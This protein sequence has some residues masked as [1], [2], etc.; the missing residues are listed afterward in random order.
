[1]IFFINSFKQ[2]RTIPGDQNKNSK[3]SRT[4]ARNIQSKQ[5]QQPQPQPQLQQQPQLQEQQPQQHNLPKIYNNRQKPSLI[6][7]DTTADQ[8]LNPQ[9]PRY[10]QPTY[11]R[12][13]RQA[14]ESTTHN[15]TSVTLPPIVE[16]KRPPNKE[17]PTSTIEGRPSAPHN[18]RRRSTDG[19]E[20]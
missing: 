19:S 7:T 12:R 3:K 17:T 14:V 16:K 6:T 1:M 2:I 4:R 10:Q 18:S 15:T 8:Q 5:E 13:L 9:P 20:N 11:S